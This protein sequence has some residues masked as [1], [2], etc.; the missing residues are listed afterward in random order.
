MED[1]MR[2]M[3]RL[4]R[5]KIKLAVIAALLLT[6]VLIVF[7]CGGGGGGTTTAGGGVSGTGSSTGT[8]TA[9]GSIF[10]NGIEYDT[11]SAEITVNGNKNAT[12]DDLKIGMK[13]NIK[14]VN[15]VA[16]SIE[17]DSDV[18]GQVSNKGA[19]SFEVLG[20][21]VK[22]NTQTEYCF[23]DEQDNCTFSFAD[24]SNDDFVEVSGYFD[25]GGN[26]IAT[27]V[28]KDDQDPVIYQVKGFISGLDTFNKTFSINNLAV[29]YSGLVINPLG[30][31]DGVFVEVRGT[32]NAP[33][34]LTATKVEVEVTQASPGKA[35]SLE[36]IVTQFTS[37]ENFT[38]NGQPVLT[39]SQTQF[40]GDPL[41]IALNVKVEIEGTVNSSGK[42]VAKEVKI[43]DED[44]ED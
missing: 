39:N 1:I 18:K 32:L 30:I 13:V 34:E 43:E 24:L 27:L 40:E 7:A 22:V 38:V 6:V 9:F 14:T 28:K 10:V 23:D 4:L 29:D 41:S 2:L 16:S 31:A 17:Y 26:I 15:N 25:S 5:V 35:L 3:N 42:L 19:A 36:G 8:V 20:Q 21:T 44:I 33:D 11:T 12:Q 37:Q